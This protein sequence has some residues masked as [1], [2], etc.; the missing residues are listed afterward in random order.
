VGQHGVEGE[1]PLET[2]DCHQVLQQQIGLAEI[3][4]YVASGTRGGS[5]P[6]DPIEQFGVSPAQ[7]SDV[8]F[9]DV[10]TRQVLSDHANEDVF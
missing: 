3:V 1:Q 5:L 10:S 9:T 8:P 2:D 7:G 6:V 4:L